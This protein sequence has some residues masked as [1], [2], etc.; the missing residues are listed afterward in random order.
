MNKIHKQMKRAKK[1]GLTS[2]DLLRMKMIAEKKTKE[3][4]QTATEKAFLYML[5]IPLNV[6]VNDNWSKTAKKK[7]PKF[8]EDVISLY[9]SVCEGVVT[10]K[11]LAKL[12]YDYA[13]VKITADWMDKKAEDAL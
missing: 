6:L 5:A 1:S 4:E 8:I 2:A 13:G 7:A 9:D 11:E 3:M 10:E 12:L